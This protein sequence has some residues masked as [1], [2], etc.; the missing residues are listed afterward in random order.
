MQKELAP[1][2][3]DLAHQEGA[4]PAAKRASPIVLAIVALVAIA[5]LSYSGF[6]WAQKR[7]LQSTVSSQRAQVQNLTKQVAA[8]KST[9]DSYAKQIASYNAASTPTLNGK[10]GDT[11]TT[12]GGDLVITSYS[13]TSRHAVASGFTSIAPILEVDLKLTNSTNTNQTYTASQFTFTNSA[14]IVLSSIDHEISD[15]RTTVL[16]TATL[17]PGGTVSTKV[18]F[19]TYDSKQGTLSWASPLGQ[20][21]NVTL[22]NL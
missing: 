7:S 20:Q 4:R 19:D 15:S 1:Q 6:S 8:L 18:Y 5:G 3:N 11:V 13:S 12:K 2:P 14:K 22:P 17:A 21:V 10:V 9:N 16:D